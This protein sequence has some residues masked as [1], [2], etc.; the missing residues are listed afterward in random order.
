VSAALLV[1][2][3]HATFRH[4]GADLLRHSFNRAFHHTTTAAHRQAD[5]VRP[6]TQEEAGTARAAQEQRGL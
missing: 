6:V 5:T 1:S 2:A 4:T 3:G